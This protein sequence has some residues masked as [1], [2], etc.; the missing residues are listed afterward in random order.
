[1]SAINFSSSA[2]KN[3]QPIYDAVEASNRLGYTYIN[4]DQL[5][6]IICRSSETIR[7]Q[8]TREPHKL[9]PRVPF[10]DGTTSVVWMLKSVWKWQDKMESTDC[11]ILELTPTNK[12]RRG[13]PTAT[14][15]KA[16]HL[17]GLSVSEYR[18]S[19]AG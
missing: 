10:T 2:S 14:E 12:S 13:A 1:M 4:I 3:S 15:K 16:A 18:K 11:E 7:T 8:I 5:S 17:V 9:P 19:Q 6:Q